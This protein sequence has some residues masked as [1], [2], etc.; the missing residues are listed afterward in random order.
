VEDLRGPGPGRA[1]Q[2]D[3]KGQEQRLADR[4]RRLLRHRLLRSRD[5][6]HLLG[7]GQS[8]AGL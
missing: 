7:L 5:Q 6:H 2:R 1:R 3:L 8:G 4:R